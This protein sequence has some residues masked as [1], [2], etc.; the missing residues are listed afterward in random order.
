MNGILQG[1]R[2][3]DV[4]IYLKQAIER[5]GYDEREIKQISKCLL[6]DLLDL[7]YVEIHLNPQRTISESQILQLHRKVKRLLAREPLQYVLGYTWFLNLK[8]QVS[9][10]VLIP[11]PETEE[12]VLGVIERLKGK[13]EGSVIDLGTGSGCIA[14][15]LKDQLPNW[16][17]TALDLS[18]E[19]L[20]VAALN[21]QLNEK[22]IAFSQMDIFHLSEWNMEYDAVVSNPPYVLNRDRFEMQQQVL[23]H[24]PHMALFVADDDPL[25][26]YRAITR[27]SAGHLLAGGV[28]AFEVHE[29]FAHEVAALLSEYGFQAT[30]QRDLQDKNRFVFG[31]R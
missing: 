17:V 28:L 16:H 26:F 19:A 31:T 25:I 5:A 11:R 13:S 4:L 21:A 10:S 24:E 7:P 18:A 14:I 29:Q 9:P 30:I 20:E 2:I 6:E 15:A 27:W 12:L 22:E 1:N 8:F 3:A 23:Q